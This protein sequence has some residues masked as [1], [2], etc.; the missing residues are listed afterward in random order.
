MPI[1]SEYT[2]GADVTAT[3][4]ATTI[5]MTTST[6]GNSGDTIL[7]A[8]AYR[9]ATP[10]AISASGGVT[11][12][13]I[14]QQDGGNGSVAILSS[15]PLASNLA[16]S[17]VIT[18]T[19][20]SATRRFLRVIGV[21]GV[22]SG[23]PDANHIGGANSTGTAPSV[24]TAGSTPAAG[25]FA[26]SVLSRYG[27]SLGDTATAGGTPSGFV[28][29]SDIIVG[30]VSPIMQAYVEDQVL[31]S[32]GTVTASPSWSSTTG[33]WEAAIA[34]FGPAASALAPPIPRRDRAKVNPLLRR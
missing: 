20:G 8:T 23:T 10:A 11:W 12:T 19:G 6:Q 2:L 5:A 1:G 24:P 26:F 17:T 15:G 4:T 14:K 32:G 29:N 31:A 27:A 21:P 25:D 30:A 3:T 7:I 22:A 33:G 13:L 16:S 18:V 34:V 28:E 9:V